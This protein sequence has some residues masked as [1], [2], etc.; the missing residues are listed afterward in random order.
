MKIN[1]GDVNDNAPEFSPDVIIIPE[2]RQPGQPGTEHEVCDV[3]DFESFVT[4]LQFSI[5]SEI[6]IRLVCNLFTFQFVS[7]LTIDRH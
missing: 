4:F 2:N 3:S 6:L 5:S 7:L 1:V